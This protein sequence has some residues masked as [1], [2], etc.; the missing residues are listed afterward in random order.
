M[1]EIWF[2][3]FFKTCIV[4]LSTLNTNKNGSL[5]S[6]K[7]GFRISWHFLT[8]IVILMFW[9]TVAPETGATCTYM[10]LT[11]ARTATQLPVF[12]GSWK[13]PFIVD[14]RERNRENCYV[15]SNA[16]AHKKKENVWGF[17]HRVSAVLCSTSTVDILASNIVQTPSDI[18]VRGLRPQPLGGIPSIHD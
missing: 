5:H 2:K 14:L 9:T 10:R 3:T 16:T 13:M 4:V 6:C 1:S 8:R 17:R 15:I 11:S 7:V 12:T 18:G